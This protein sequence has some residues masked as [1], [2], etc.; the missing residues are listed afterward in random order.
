MHDNVEINRKSLK[1]IG[2][3][4]YHF[5][6]DNLYIMINDFTKPHNMFLKICLFSQNKWIH[7][8]CWEKS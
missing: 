8:S 5:G 7:W 3:K 6:D 4:S 1:I 2:I